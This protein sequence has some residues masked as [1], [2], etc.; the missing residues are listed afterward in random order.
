MRIMGDLEN[1]ELRGY[2]VIPGIV[3]DKALAELIGDLTQVL[4]KDRAKIR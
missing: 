2:S 4:A 1:I 3:N